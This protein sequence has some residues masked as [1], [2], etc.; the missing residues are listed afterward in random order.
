MKWVGKLQV[1][2]TYDPESKTKTQ[3]QKEVYDDDYWWSESFIFRKNNVNISRSKFFFMLD[4]NMVY[5]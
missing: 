3:M 4:Q 5:L 2:E 1:K